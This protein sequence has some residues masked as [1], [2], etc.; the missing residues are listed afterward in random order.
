MSVG[1]FNIIL[2]LSLGFVS[3][4]FGVRL[5]VE[6]I[7]RWRLMQLGLEF[8]DIDEIEEAEEEDYYD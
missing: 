7:V 6:S 4:A 1:I 3:V 5:A 2:G 8:V